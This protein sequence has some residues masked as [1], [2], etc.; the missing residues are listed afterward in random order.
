MATEAMT[1][2][3]ESEVGPSLF[4]L[5]GD[6][7]YD[8]QRNCG[9]LANVTRCRAFPYIFWPE[10]FYLHLYKWTAF[11]QWKQPFCSV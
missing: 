11:T 5:D 9:H 2:P 4:D 1:M 8:Y 10:F 7:H 6:C 3:A